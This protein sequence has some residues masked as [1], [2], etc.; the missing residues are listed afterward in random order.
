MSSELGI[1]TRSGTGVD[2][3]RLYLKAA[4][5]TTL[6][7]V[8]FF[9]ASGTMILSGL[10]GS[11]ITLDLTT[12]WQSLETLLK[13]ETGG[14]AAWDS[15]RESVAGV[16]TDAVTIQVDAS[17]GQADATVP[18]KVFASGSPLLI[19]HGVPDELRGLVGVTVTL[20]GEMET[21][22]NWKNGPLVT[23]SISASG[24]ADANSCVV[25]CLGFSEVKFLVV[26]TTGTPQMVGEV[27][28]DGTNWYGALGTIQPTTTRYSGSIQNASSGTRMM[29]ACQGWV[30]A[31]LRW[32]SGAGT[33]VVVYG[34]A[35]GSPFIPPLASVD[36]SGRQSVA[37]SQNNVSHAATFSTQSLVGG[38]LE[39]RAT[40]QSLV[41][42]GQATRWAAT[43]GGHGLAW[44]GQMP[45]A[46]NWC[47]STE[48]TPLTANGT[49][50]IASKVAGKRHFVNHI[51]VQ[52][53]GTGS[54]DVEIRDED[55]R[56]VWGPFQLDGDGATPAMCPPIFVPMDP[57]DG[58]TRGAVNKDL[59]LVLSNAS[60]TISVRATIRGFRSAM[61]A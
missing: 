39:G 13:A 26:T 44:P 45:G 6:T 10:G 31:R 12:S 8:R 51:S 42:E 11:G 60:G 9:D 30:Y 2:L 19:G 4:S 22:S 54:V 50:T 52:N 47:Y 28:M 20:S 14:S 33:G 16:V 23:A 48:A 32:S 46:E 7:N 35:T 53:T 36:S 24:S 25:P 43:P 58:T 5:A 18:T 38:A 34:R 55:G 57:I 3:S 15:I 56:T 1:R 21:A 59:Q 17:F 41:S 27:S 37:L 29:V 61:G 40:E 49:T